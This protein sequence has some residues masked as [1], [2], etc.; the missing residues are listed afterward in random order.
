MDGLRL[1]GSIYRGFPVS[2]H[3]GSHPQPYW[4]GEVV[5]EHMN[6]CREEGFGIRERKVLGCRVIQKAKSDLAHLLRFISLHD[7]SLP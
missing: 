5:G 6:L 2:W 4:C 1:Q 7:L 3:T